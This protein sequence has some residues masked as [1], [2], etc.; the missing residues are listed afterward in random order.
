[1][2]EPWSG[3]FAEDDQTKQQKS[4]N[5]EDFL[6]NPRRFDL[7]FFNL[8]WRIRIIV[9]LSIGLQIKPFSGERLVQQR[10]AVVLIHHHPDLLQP[11]DAVGLVPQGQK[12]REIIDLVRILVIR[13]A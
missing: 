10:L 8:N 6:G 12:D 13:S 3:A 5:I 4:R 1:M 2:P 7:D 9:E 11:A